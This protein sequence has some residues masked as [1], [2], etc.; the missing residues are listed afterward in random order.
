MIFN[1]DSEILA[2][3]LLNTD[4]IDMEIIE[5]SEE[6]KRQQE[7]TLAK[8]WTKWGGL[9]PCGTVLD[10]DGASEVCP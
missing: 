2:V 5:R 4:S 6:K 9:R 7:E 1:V 8:I 3:A 10:F